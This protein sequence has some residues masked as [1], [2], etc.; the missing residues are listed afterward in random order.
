LVSGVDNWTKSVFD[1]IFPFDKTI[2]LSSPFTGPS[3]FAQKL[4]VK[5]L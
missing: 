2:S 1:W 4:T 3:N 5:F